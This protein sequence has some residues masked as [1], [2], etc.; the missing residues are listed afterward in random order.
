MIPEL[1]I[2]ED[3]DRVE[4]IG[5]IGIGRCFTYGGKHKRSMHDPLMPYTEN[6][7]KEAYESLRPTTSINH[8]YEK[9][10]KLKD[11]LHTKTA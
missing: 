8:F 7:T 10:L 2:V 9:L 1:A 6:M 3:A 11:L 4:A 5:A